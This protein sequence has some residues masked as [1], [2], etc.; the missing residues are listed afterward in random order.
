MTNPESTP[1]KKIVENALMPDAPKKQKRG[2]EDVR[3]VD[4][5]VKSKRAATL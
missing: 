1:L 3:D 2:Y 5:P 4:S